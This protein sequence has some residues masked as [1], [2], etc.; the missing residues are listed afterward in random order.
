[1]SALGSPNVVRPASNTG[2]STSAASSPRPVG[3]SV[4]AVTMPVSAFKPTRRTA[5]RSTEAPSRQAPHGLTPPLRRL[6]GWPHRAAD[7]MSWL[8][9]NA[10]C[11]LPAGTTERRKP[12][13]RSI[14]HRAIEGRGMRAQRERDPSGGARAASMA[15]ASDSSVGS[16]K[17]T[18]V[19]C[20]RTR[21]ER[22]AAPPRHHRPARGV[23]LERRHAEVLFAGKEQRAARGQPLGDHLVRLPAE[24]RDRRSR[25]A[26][27]SRARSGPSPITTSRRFS[28]LQARNREIDAACRRPAGRRRDRSRRPSARR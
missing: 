6:R 5:A 10:F 26:L 25:P 1:M 23:G 16:E 27:S 18:P 4:R 17:N 21:V 9:A 8:T 13:M 24:E 22:A 7:V 14:E 12:R 3:L 19:S 20:S 28:R 11:S 2:H 15:S